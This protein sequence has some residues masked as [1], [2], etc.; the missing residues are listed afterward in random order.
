M[1]RMMLL[2][3]LASALFLYDPQAA[4]RY[5]DRGLEWVG[6]KHTTGTVARLA[7]PERPREPAASGPLTP[8]RR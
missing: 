3:G 1:A 5:V 6:W 8:P 7:A 4:L 2:V